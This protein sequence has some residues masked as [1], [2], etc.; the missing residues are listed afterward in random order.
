MD[1]SF[2]RETFKGVRMP[3]SLVTPPTPENQTASGLKGLL[4]LNQAIPGIEALTQEGKPLG[5]IYL[6]IA[7]YG[8]LEGNYGKETFDEI[9]TITSDI[10][11]SFS[12]TLFR[13][14]DR[15]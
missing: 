9:F 7:K 13:K 8:H 4:T 10:L 1:E 11:T 3:F 15:L 6:D 14:E 5:I 12:G 2:S